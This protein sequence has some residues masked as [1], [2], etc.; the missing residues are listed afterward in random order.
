MRLVRFGF[1]SAILIALAACIN[2]PEEPAPAP[3]PAMPLAYESPLPPSPLVEETPPVR[4]VVPPSKPI[5]A[6][7]LSVEADCRPRNASG[8]YAESTLEIRKDVV[9]RM[10]SVFHIVG[11][12]QCTFE[13]A[14][15]KQ[16]KTRPFIELHGKRTR[17]IARIREQGQHISLSFSDC[18][19]RCTP[20]ETF[21][22]VWP[23]Q[24]EQTGKCE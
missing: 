23:V 6:G 1:S 9:R 17:C 15:M 14:D 4:P 19:Q 21:K 3:P 20:P 11:H 10:R 13:L 12:G 16:T 8:D 5:P 7:P 18:E 2:T 24:I 22:Y